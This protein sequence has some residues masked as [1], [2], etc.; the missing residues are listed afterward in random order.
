M[1]FDSSKLKQHS[2]KGSFG[3]K[4][5]KSAIDTS[6]LIAL[7]EQQDLLVTRLKNT[8]RKSK[9]IF[10]LPQTYPIKGKQVLIYHNALKSLGITVPLDSTQECFIDRTGFC[11][12]IVLENIQNGN[13]IVPVDY[14]ENNFVVVSSNQKQASII[15]PR[16]SFLHRL[17]DRVDLEFYETIAT[18]SRS[19]AVIGTISNIVI[20]QGVER[21]LRENSYRDKDAVDIKASIRT[22][23]GSIAMLAELL[24]G[25]REIEDVPETITDLKKI[26]YFYGL[27]ENIKKT[28]KKLSDLSVP[29]NDHLIYEVNCFRYGDPEL[30]LFYFKA[31][32]PVFIIFTSD[33]SSETNDSLKDYFDPEFI[34]LNGNNRSRLINNLLDIQMIDYLLEYIESL[35]DS[36]AKKSDGLLSGLKAMTGSAESDLSREWHELNEIAGVLRLSEPAAV[37]K[38]IADNYE[39]LGNTDDLENIQGQYIRSLN[40][41]IKSQII[42]PRSEA[43]DR[44]VCDLI[45][46]CSSSSSLNLYSNTQNFITKFSS[47]SEDE[48]ISMLREIDKNMQFENQNN[49]LINY[50]LFKYNRDICDTAGVK[51]S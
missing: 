25:I 7:R 39:V 15:N 6:A 49:L 17:L 38:N 34:I 9:G 36:F 2:Q 30:E 18:F 44:L 12:E 50:W 13:L 40:A 10:S 26:H 20:E 51:F 42:F 4:T 43:E 32:K 31:H 19:E 11:P 37:Q 24:E 47:I 23:S 46:K 1:A 35:R 27:A 14:L 5:Q 21:F 33:D 41:D 8:W 22:P 28:H 29:K 16:Y 45:S 48:K 3:I